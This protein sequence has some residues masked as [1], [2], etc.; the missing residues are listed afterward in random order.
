MTTTKSF[1]ASKTCNL[2]VFKTKSDCELALNGY[3]IDLQANGYG[4]MLKSGSAHGGSELEYMLNEEPLQ[5]GYGLLQRWAEYS[6]LNEKGNRVSRTAN[7]RAI[8]KK[9]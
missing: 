9:D 4:D 5:E 3:L 1:I 6:I 7:A 2:F 8:Y